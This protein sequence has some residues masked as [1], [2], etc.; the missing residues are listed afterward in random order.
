[1]ANEKTSN[2]QEDPMHPE[3][4]LLPCLSSILKICCGRAGKAADPAYPARG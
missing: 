4:H 2:T 1:M 3:E